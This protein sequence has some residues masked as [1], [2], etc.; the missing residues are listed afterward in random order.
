[1]CKN[2]ETDDELADCA[3]DADEHHPEDW[4][5]KKPRDSNDRRYNP[6]QGSKT[7]TEGRCNAPLSNWEERYGEVRY[8]MQLPYS[9][10]ADSDCD[11]CKTHK[12]RHDLMKRAKEA[13][14]HGL[15]SKTIKHVFEKLD[16]WQK[17]TVLGWYDSYLQESTYDFEI[18]LEAHTIDFSGYDGE[19]PLEIE[20]ELDED[21]TFEVGVPIPTAHETRAF[22]LYRAALM[23]IKA[24]LGERQVT[25]TSDD[26][27]VMERETVVSVTEDGRQ[28]TDTE[29]HHLNVALSRNDQRKEDLLAL[30]GVPLQA[31]EDDV[32]VNVESPG[33]LVLD[34]DEGESANNPV[35][36]AMDDTNVGES[37]DSPIRD[38]S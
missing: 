25:D 17:L 10:F 26:T 20:A 15:Y 3:Y 14:T 8:C 7:P 2:C 27:G 32:S 11:F 23:D 37:S 30:G 18:D 4:D 33:E 21:G 19:L 34:L 1:M 28:I 12:Q 38:D 13:F 6:Y 22:A 29:E 16:P 36:T 31:D 24:G 35:E 9:T 5:D